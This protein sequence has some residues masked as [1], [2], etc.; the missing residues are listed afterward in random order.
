M[1]AVW[2][3]RNKLYVSDSICRMHILHME[4]FKKDF[5]FALKDES[6]V[7]SDHMVNKYPV[8]KRDADKDIAN[9]VEEEVQVVR[10]DV[11][12]VGS[13]VNSMILTRKHLI[14]AN[15]DE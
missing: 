1:D 9:N 15:D 10:N 6:I 11:F 14:I 4:D 5:P 12:S 7:E 3:T 13:L 2:D 8:F